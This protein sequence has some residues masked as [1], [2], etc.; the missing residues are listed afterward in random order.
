[1][2]DSNKDLLRELYNIASELDVYEYKRNKI[3]TFMRD[4]PC[5]CF[6]KNGESGKYEFVNN[7][8]CNLIE[9][10]DI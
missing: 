3:L 10:K 1:M 2:L 9:K 4:I 7:A 8:F 6:V 5:I